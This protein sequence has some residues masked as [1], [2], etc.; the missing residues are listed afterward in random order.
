MGGR[1]QNKLRFVK[2]R[3]MV[4]TSFLRDIIVSR[5]I[6]MNTAI[7]PTYYPKATITCACGAIYVTGSTLEKNDVELCSA[8]HPFYTGKQKMLYSARR[9]E[10]FEARTSH[11][12]SIVKSLATKKA[13]RAAKRKPKV[14][15]EETKSVRVKK[16]AKKEA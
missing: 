4:L 9:V 5:I 2:N 1:I 3:G 11:K 15:V 12:K 13:E 16:A 14:E 10:K 6:S 7:H 8:C